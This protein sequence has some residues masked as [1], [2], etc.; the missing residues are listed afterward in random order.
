METPEIK[1]FLDSPAGLSMKNYLLGKLYEL[2]DIDLISEKDTTAKQ[3]L[4]LKA[5][6][7]A[8]KKLYDILQEIMTL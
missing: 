5:Q 3:A 7:R 4:E 8:Y 1:K 2:K 6:K